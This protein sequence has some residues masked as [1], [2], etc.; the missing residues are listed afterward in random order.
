[1]GDSIVTAVAWRG[2]SWEIILIPTQANESYVE[3]T[4]E[5]AEFV[6]K[7]MRTKMLSLK[8]FVPALIVI[9]SVSGVVAFVGAAPSL[10]WDIQTVDSEG[11][12]GS[13]SSM[14]LDSSGN[15][16]I[17]YRDNT[18]K[19]L[20]Y[21]RWNGNTWEIQTVDGDWGGS[22]GASMALDS[23][24][25]PHISYYDAA[26]LALKYARW[27]GSSWDIQT[28][29]SEWH[30]GGVYAMGEGVSMALDSSGNP[31]ISYCARTFGTGDLKYARWTGSSWDIQTV[32]SEGVVGSYSSIALDSSDNPHI[33]YLDNTNVALK[34][35]RWNGNS[36]EIQTVDTE[37]NVSGYSSMVLDSSGNPHISYRT[38]IRSVLVDLIT[39]KPSWEEGNLKYTRWTGSSWAIQTVDSEEY[40]DLGLYMSMA[41]DSSGNPHMSYYDDTN[42][43]LKYAQWTGSSWE[44]QTVEGG[45]GSYSSLVLDSS[46]NP[47]ISCCLGGGLRYVTVKTAQ[48]EVPTNNQEFE[49]PWT[50][51]GVGTAVI[52]VIVVAVLVLKRKGK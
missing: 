32:D 34:Y 47:H 23:S 3:Y 35:A 51:I 33:S 5:R 26:D 11:F 31:H 41:L 48:P 39:G 52:I 12:V 20:K 24:G 19:A 17:S 7:V 6:N 37:G 15:P 10:E 9:F 45:G 42:N 18:N 49:V 4:R 30:G 29:D 28:V 13:Y 43:C 8:L 38:Y 2:K 50:W 27:T 25:N 16:H 22:G 21:A 14:A 36:W 44:I 40:V 46:G 1:V